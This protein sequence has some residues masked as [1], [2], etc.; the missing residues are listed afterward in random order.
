MKSAVF[1][2]ENFESG[3]N[4]SATRVQTANDGGVGEASRS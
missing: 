3:K 4:K 2:R 1:G